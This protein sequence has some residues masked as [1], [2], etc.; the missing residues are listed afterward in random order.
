MKNLLMFSKKMIKKI[1]PSFFL[2]SVSSYTAYNYGSP[3][4][5]NFISEYEFQRT[6]KLKEKQIKKV[7]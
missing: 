1:L 6:E 2:F 5:S 7:K 3:Y 4:I